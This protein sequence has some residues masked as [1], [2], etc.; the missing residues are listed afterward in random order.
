MSAP[1]VYSIIYLHKYELTY[2]YFI[3]RVIINLL[4]YYLLLALFFFQ[5]WLLALLQIGFLFSFNMLHST[6]IL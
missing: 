6:V 3:L 5:L 4:L 1:F 2:I